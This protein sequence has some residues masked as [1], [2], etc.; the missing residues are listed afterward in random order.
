VIISRSIPDG[1][2]P[3]RKRSLNFDLKLL[4]VEPTNDSDVDV[5]LDQRGF[6]MMD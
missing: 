3:R 2:Y 1:E 5:P 6:G 4:D